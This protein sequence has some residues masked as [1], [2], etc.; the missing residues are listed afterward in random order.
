MYWNRQNLNLLHCV[1]KGHLVIN[2]TFKHYFLIKREINRQITINLSSKDL[3]TSDED[4]YPDC[5]FYIAD[6]NFFWTLDPDADW[7]F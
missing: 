6:W 3:L 7:D 4:P 5:V 1:L 2:A